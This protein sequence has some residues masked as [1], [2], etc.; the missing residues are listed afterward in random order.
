MA[1]NHQ[2]L[3]S[4]GVHLTTAGPV[5]LLLLP[6][7]PLCFVP[8]L[9]FFGVALPASAAMPVVVGTLLAVWTAV[10]LLMTWRQPRLRVVVC[11]AAIV[12]LAAVGAGNRVLLWAGVGGMIAA[13]LASLRARRRDA[14]QETA[15]CP[16]A[17]CAD[18]TCAIKQPDCTT[19]SSTM[20][21]STHSASSFAWR[22]RS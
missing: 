7:C 13:G 20:L 1:T 3:G 8:I 11:I 14:A 9:A 4:A 16:L 18:Q 6:K 10:L 17:L 22:D 5:S 12:S 21:A 19:H 15:L 2:R